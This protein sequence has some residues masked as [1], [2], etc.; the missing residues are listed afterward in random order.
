MVYKVNKILLYEEQYLKKRTDMITLIMDNSQ[1][2][3]QY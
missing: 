2:K 1:P 3:D